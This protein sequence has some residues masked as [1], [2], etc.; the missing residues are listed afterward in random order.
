MKTKFIHI[1]DIHLVDEGLLL[2]GGVPTARLDACLDDISRWHP[3]AAFCVISGDLA[4]FAEVE[5]YQALKA[6][7]AVYPLP[8][9]LLIGN[10]DDRAV[11]QSVFPDHPK[12]MNEFV[13]HRF[14]IE[15]GVFLFL[16]TTK[17]GRDVHEGQLCSYRLDWLKQQ[18]AE[19]GDKPT[20]LFLHHPPFEI[21]IPYVDNIRLIEAEAFAKALRHG[22]DI[23]HVLT[24][25]PSNLCSKHW[26]KAVPPKPDRFM[27][28]VDTP[29]MQ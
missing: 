22:R 3:D 23:R 19:A 5:A 24:S 17:E 29:L 18:L 10:H 16:D 13:Q 1:T 15:Q 8:C 4:E 20:Y 11:F 21:G 27:A 25:F 2:N 28:Y 7:L 12:D 6:R 14:E 9:F 26:P